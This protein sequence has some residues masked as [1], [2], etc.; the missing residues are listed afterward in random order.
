AWRQDYFQDCLHKKDDEITDRDIEDKNLILFGNDQT[1]GLI[2][3]VIGQIPLKFSADRI[4][5]GNRVY[6]GADLGVRMIYPNPLNKKRYIVIIGGNHMTN[7]PFEEKCLAIEGWY[8]FMVWK[9]QQK[10]QILVDIGYF[11]RR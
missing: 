6:Q 10:D 2:K 5:L 8:D 11:D 4:A 3:R 7:L 1:N 9:P